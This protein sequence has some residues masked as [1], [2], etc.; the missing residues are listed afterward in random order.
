MCTKVKRPKVD[1]ADA[2]ADAGAVV[3]ADPPLHYLTPICLGLV[4]DQR[5]FLRQM[6]EGGGNATTQRNAE[7]QVVDTEMERSL[8][9]ITL[10]R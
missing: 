5:L 6:R 8:C 10:S 4:I 7:E 9:S 3:G 2:D 1:A